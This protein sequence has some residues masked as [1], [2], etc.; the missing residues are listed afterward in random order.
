MN[1]AVYDPFTFASSASLSFSHPSLVRKRSSLDE[2][3]R[4]RDSMRPSKRAR[5]TL[6]PRRRSRSSACK[7]SDWS[8]QP[9]IAT[10]T[11]QR[12]LLIPH[13]FRL[14]EQGGLFHSQDDIRMLPAQLIH[15]NCD[16][17]MAS[18]EPVAAPM[19]V[20]DTVMTIQSTPQV[21]TLQP[22][23]P[24]VPA[25]VAVAP[26][27]SS[28]SAPAP[29]ASSPA[30]S[31]PPVTAAKFWA[32]WNAHCTAA[33]PSRW[34][35]VPH[36]NDAA[37]QPPALAVVP[38]PAPVAV[39][40]PQSVSASAPAASAAPSPVSA[41]EFWV[42]WNARCTAAGPSRWA[43]YLDEED[44]NHDAGEVDAIIETPQ[45]K[46][47]AR[48]VVPDLVLTPA[49]PPPLS[50]ALVQGA[51]PFLLSVP[52][53][54]FA[55]ASQECGAGPSGWAAKD[56]EEGT[57]ASVSMGTARRTAAADGGSSARS[58]GWQKT[59]ARKIK[60]NHAPDAGSQAG[61][62]AT[63]HRQ[64][65]PLA[66]VVNVD[67]RSSSPRSASTTPPV[68]KSPVVVSAPPPSAPPPGP[69]I[70]V[71]QPLTSPWLVPP[72]ADPASPDVVPPRAGNGLF[73]NMPPFDR[74]P[75]RAST[76]RDRRFLVPSRRQSFMEACAARPAFTPGAGGS[77][78]RHVKKAPV[79]EAEAA[80]AVESIKED[81][82]VA[83]TPK[84]AVVSDTHVPK[85]G[86]EIF[87]II[88]IYP[89]ARSRP[90]LHVDRPGLTLYYMAL[91]ADLLL[92]SA[93]H[94]LRGV[95]DID[96]NLEDFVL[97]HY[98]PALDAE[99]ACWNDYYL[100]LSLPGPHWLCTH[101]IFPP[102][103]FFTSQ[104]RRSSWLVSARNPLPSIPSPPAHFWPPDRH[105][106]LPG[107]CDTFLLPLSS[108]WMS[109]SLLVLRA[110]PSG[111][112]ALLLAYG[113][114]AIP[115]SSLASLFGTYTILSSF[116]PRAS[117]ARPLARLLSMAHL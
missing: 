97:V 112:L 39:A 40:H 94:S 46:G 104:L 61:A 24:L 96:S 15:F 16:V 81:S 106:L 93:P 13:V 21:T 52:L 117:P 110:F 36:E 68:I 90:L 1:Y 23:A 85:H 19:E 103:T 83:L 100:G 9:V 26:I 8:L 59:R 37:S 48:E 28:V 69:S 70:R 65:V 54:P 64:R 51:N 10:P 88:I 49:S 98:T 77:I 78:P 53:T 11:S 105:H 87:F 107:P 55:T 108:L 17:R 63:G 57:G 38:P 3:R 58:S 89:W 34:A 25:P 6:R 113:P 86:V 101:A 111:P 29:A 56:D 20:D 95:L 80:V 30:A 18:P 66:N 31:S 4:D 82:D 73:D 32:R 92:V 79:P 47:K 91:D 116:I 60:E 62:P 114:P 99:N 12:P 27:Q 43:A 50:P 102:P 71:P 42:R 76:C 7:T 84:E 109:L 115:S 67:R 35:A 75:R 33:G 14:S 5:P 22:P 44:G 72:A 74:Q 41:A 2:D 45:D